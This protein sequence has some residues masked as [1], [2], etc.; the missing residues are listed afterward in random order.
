MEDNSLIIIPTYNESE[1]IELIINKI[2]QLD[3]SNDILV[4]DDNSPDGTSEIVSGLKENFVNRIFLLKRDKKL[5]LGS[6]YIEGFK[7]ALKEE[8]AYIFE[9]DADLSHNPIEIKYLKELLSDKSYDVA[10]GSRYLE[11]ISVVNWPLSRI[12]LSYFANLYVRVITGMKIKDATSGF[13]GYTN[14]ALLSLNLDNI[15][16]NGY[17]FQIEMK[18]KSYL[19]NFKI[20]EVPIIFSDRKFGISK[21]NGSIISEAIFGVIAMR[22]KK[23]FNIK[24]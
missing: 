14:K 1:N 12:F 21:L 13:V 17:A 6:A 11:G 2:L 4:V 24:F 8:Y 15:R 3:D 10:I 23:I 7:W 16:F 9:M 19:K 18:Y 22:I 5:G 20:I